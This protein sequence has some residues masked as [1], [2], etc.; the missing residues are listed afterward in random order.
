M[1]PASFIHHH[2]S[3]YT[4]DDTNVNEQI[5]I[6]QNEKQ[7]MQRNA[8]VSLAL[9][10]FKKIKIQYFMVYLILKIF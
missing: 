4:L 5:I 2:H 7:K 3:I 8:K 1:D 10:G 9:L 6:H